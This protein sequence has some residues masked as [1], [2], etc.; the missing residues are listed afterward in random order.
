[1]SQVEPDTLSELNPTRGEEPDPTP[2]APSILDRLRAEVEATAAPATRDLPVGRIS[3]LWARYR[4]LS[5]SETAELE[6]A[7]RQ[8]RHLA[9][10]TGRDDS[11]AAEIAAARLLAT[12]CVELL[13]MDEDGTLRPL[14]DELNLGDGP[15]RYNAELIDLLQLRDVYDDL[16][17]R[18]SSI[19]V[20][21]ALHRWG[22]SSSPLLSTARLLSVWMSGVTAEAIS[23]V[24]EG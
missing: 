17:E 3:S 7:A 19:E 8:R 11:E 20:V 18:P 2:S 1:M 14:A 16:G 6:R 9:D 23:E 5:S 24:I 12:A 4:L 22:D 13:W 15:L 21:R 10:R